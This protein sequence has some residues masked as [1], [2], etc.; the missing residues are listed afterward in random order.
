MGVEQS[1]DDL[2]MAARGGVMQRRP[3]RFVDVGIGLNQSLD[4]GQIATQGGQ[5][6]HAFVL[7]IAHFGPYPLGVSQGQRNTW[8]RRSKGQHQRRHA[9]GVDA[10]GVETP[11]QQPLHSGNLIARNRLEKVLVGASPGQS[12]NTQINSKYNEIFDFIHVN[13][14]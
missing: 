6:Q 12:M 1:L 11:V 10:V 5:H 13:Y 9:L 8:R 7:V 3:T 4:Q 2:G 14:C